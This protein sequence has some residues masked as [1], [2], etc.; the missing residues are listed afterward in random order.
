MK[1]P[2][3]IKAGHYVLHGIQ[4]KKV[5]KNWV[6]LDKSFKTLKACVSAININAH[7]DPNCD[8]IHVVMPTEIST[9]LINMM[10]LVKDKKVI[11]DIEEANVAIEADA[12]IET[13][14]TIEADKKNTETLAK[15]KK[16]N[17]DLAR[18]TLKI[19]M[20]SEMRAEL[21]E[22]LKLELSQ[23]IAHEIRT[24]LNE[25]IRS[26]SK[27][28]LHIRDFVDFKVKY[29][30]DI[31]SKE[32][33]Q[34][35]EKL[36]TKSEKKAKAEQAKIAKREA[37]IAIHEM[38]CAVSLAQQMRAQRLAT[39]T[40]TS[41]KQVK[42]DAKLKAQSEKRCRKLMNELNGKRSIVSKA[43]SFISGLFNK[44]LTS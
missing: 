22:E 10:R 11:A 41:E 31:N 30:C 29:E 14:A 25:S 12:A 7:I 9:Q 43:T 4:I 39:L 24:E 17:D 21:R 20:R 16:L 36:R 40:R 5:G 27:H 3:K 38:E 15:I 42:E 37:Q 34:Y 35:M 2:T 6:Y 28:T 26:E 1:K 18:M 32:F 33:D 13:N 23:G 8:P 19:K 44:K